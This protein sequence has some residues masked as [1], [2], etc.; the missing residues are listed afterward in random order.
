MAECVDH[1]FNAQDEPYRS[2]L[3]FLRSFILDFSERVEEQRKNNTPFYYY[4]KKWFC[5]ISYDPK[6]KEIYISFVHGNKI[7]H[8]TLLSEG[9]KKMKI[10][11]IDAH[12]DIDIKSLEEILTMAIKIHASS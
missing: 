4:Q 3:L 9:R 8:P 5:F 11:R 2:C 1:F 6:G 7:S 10:F 12:E